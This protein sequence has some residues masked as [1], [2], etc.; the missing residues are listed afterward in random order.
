MGVQ[1]RGKN[2][3]QEEY[4]GEEAIESRKVN[5]RDLDA[6]Q[7]RVLVRSRAHACCV[8]FLK[9]GTLPV[10]HVRVHVAH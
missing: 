5:N 3:V 7:V 2:T 8:V 9:Q 1:T 4:D 6:S 10:Q